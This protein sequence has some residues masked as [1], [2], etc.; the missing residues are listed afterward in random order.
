M[1]RFDMTYFYGPPAE[2]VVRPEVL[3]DIIASGMTLLPLFAD[4]K[5]NRETLRLLAELDGNA[6]ANVFD[7][8]F[9][10]L[11]LSEDAAAVDGVVKAVVEDYRGG[12]TNALG[13]LVGQCMRASKGKGNPN[14]LREML[15]KALNG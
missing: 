3:G 13:F 2:Q 4:T 8:R 14:I 7:P 5:T 12:K 15:E 6:R 9:R 11:Y 10:E 1:N